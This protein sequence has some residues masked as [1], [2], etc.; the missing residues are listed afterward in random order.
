[1]IRRS[2]VLVLLVSLAACGREDNPTVTSPGSSSSS[3]TEFAGSV[4]PVSIPPAAG[5]ALL[6]A[7][8][9]DGRRVE[10]E[11]RDGPPGY[12]V[13]YIE[14]PVQEDASG[15]T[16]DVKGGAVLEVHMEHASAADLANGGVPVYT[17]PKRIPGPGPVLEAVDAGD[18]EGVLTWVL[19]VPSVIPF[20]VTTLTDPPRLVVEVQASTT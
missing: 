6:T 19:G 4:S 14:R 18:F 8:R 9:V 20:R 2:L 16:I 5:P 13:Q 15:K 7:V 17:G 1:M 11:F 10:F 3:T 12:R